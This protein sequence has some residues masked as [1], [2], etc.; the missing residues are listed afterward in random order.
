MKWSNR[1][2]LKYRMKLAFKR[3]LRPFLSSTPRPADLRSVP[4]RLFTSNVDTHHSLRLMIQSL[5]SNTRHPQVRFRVADNNSQDGSEDSL[6]AWENENVDFQV[7]RT[8]EVF[9]HSH[10]LDMMFRD[11][12]E[13]YWMA[14]D[15]DMLFLTP[16]PI[17][18]MLRVMEANPD[19]HLLSAERVPFRANVREPRA[20]KIIDLGEQ[21]STWLFCVRTSLRDQLDCSFAFCQDEKHEHL[22]YDTGG[23]MLAE[24]RAKG[25]QYGVMPGGF[26][27]KYHHFGS[28]SWSRTGG[29]E[30]VFSE[31]KQLQE[32]DIRRLGG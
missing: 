32:N 11:C 21:P 10:W 31:F 12:A 17:A 20:G 8:C 25:L 4:V 1:L 24:M 15:S 27:W 2:Y 18:D 23:R 6:K 26:K 5:R 7:D 29:G 3:A 14:I 28:M 22:Y 9:P 30:G 13:P 19:L 16:D